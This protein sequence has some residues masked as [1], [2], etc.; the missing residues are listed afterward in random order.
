MK[1][2]IVMVGHISQDVLIDH[3]S[4]RQD[5]V[6]GAVVYSSFAA[7]AAGNLVKV[8]TK[9]SAEDAH[10]LYDLKHQL[11][12][13]KVIPSKKSTSIKNT[14]F[15]AD[16]ECREVVLLSQADP[17]VLE[18]IEGTA[19]IYY[20]AGLFVG[21]LPDSLIKPLSERGKVA[22]DAQG[23]LRSL[24]AEGT[25]IF[26]D[27]TRKHELLPFITFFKTDAAEA[28]ILT[29]LDDMREAVT[30]LHEWGAKEVMLTHNSE[31]MVYADGNIYTAPYTNRNTS[32]RTGR[33]DTTFAAYLAW[34]KDHFVQ[35]STR[36]A[37][38]LCSIKM[39]TPGVFR[40]T[41]Q[42]VFE[43]MEEDKKYK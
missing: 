2:D 19:S 11:V 18:E 41:L 15:T 32:G 1:F 35:E 4:H 43:R 40:G 21:E 30:L 10:I 37:A 29:G 14:Y 5:I 7:A 27:W 31:V 42:D 38:A 6:G 3:L 39:E 13:W 24:D 16:K 20:L 33:G 8:I 36:F 9:L 34:R 25:L 28:N 12:E 26:K 17:F 23:V 22:L